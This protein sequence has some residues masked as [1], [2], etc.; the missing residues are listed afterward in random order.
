MR[1]SR[2]G[3]TLAFAGLSLVLGT[4]LGDGAEGACATLDWASADGGTAGDSG[5]ALAGPAA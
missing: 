3:A 5:I 2:L 4:A 1:P